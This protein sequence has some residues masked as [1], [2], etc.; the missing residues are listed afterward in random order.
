MG[1]QGSEHLSPDPQKYGD[2]TGVRHRHNP[3]RLLAV[4][5]AATAAAQID[6]H[7]NGYDDADAQESAGL[8]IGLGFHNRNPSFWV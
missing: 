3:L 6:P 5:L 4:L 1:C 2:A 7:S 8:H